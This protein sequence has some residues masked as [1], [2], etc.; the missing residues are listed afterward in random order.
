MRR[1]LACWLL[2]LVT[3]I[4][5]GAD[6]ER[7]LVITIREAP[8]SMAAPA[9][10]TPKS[11][12]NAG[13]YRSSGYARRLTDEIARDYGLTRIAEWPIKVL[14]V[15]CVVL[16]A[17]D[18]D[19][20]AAVLRLLEKDPRVE[21]VQPMHEF[22]TAASTTAYNDPYFP[23]Q[24]SVEALRVPEAHRWSQGRGVRI[25]VIDTGMDTRHPD[26][27]GRVRVTRNFVDANSVTFER[28]A[29]G[30]A[31][32]G[33]IA[34]AVNNGVGI[35]GVA[36]EVELF[37]LKA[38]WHNAPGAPA[39]CNT[40]TLAEALSFA[41][42][43]RAAIINLSLTGPRDALL[44]R[45]IEVALARGMIVVGADARRSPSE[46][47]FPISVPGVLAVTD[48]DVDTSAQPYKLAAPG[49]E[50]L[51]LVPAGHYDYLS[52][53]S[54]SSAMISGVVALLL[55]RN[56]KLTSPQIEALLER[57][58]SESGAA[59]HTR[60][61]VNA[62]NAIA[63]VVQQRDCADDDLKS[64]ALLKRT[65]ATERNTASG[66]ADRSAESRHKPARRRAT[67]GIP[68]G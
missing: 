50:V 16:S 14:G 31:V 25:A 53:V 46:D 39:V 55:E 45:L 4:A 23:L 35:V 22:H 65:R 63:Q 6:I 64:A 51:T 67:A 42:T 24:K 11:Y 19:T 47:A 9:G 29:H 49:R 18:T 20:R 52:G 37:A 40:L 10:S 66:S 36:P 54:L 43:Q 38:C 8:T 1:S 3:Q 27:K 60:R 26:L 62:C 41:I 21:S 13:N 5:T 44:T 28:D 56:R 32:A 30:T 2:C 7:Q 59:S 34:A 33:V 57:T 15:H 12:G 48:A 61:L 58:A 68:P 17:P